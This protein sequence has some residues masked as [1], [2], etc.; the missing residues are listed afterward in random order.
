MNPQS[1]APTLIDTLN[2]ASSLELFQLSTIIE[3]MLADPRRIVAVR[4]NIKLGQLVRFLGCHDGQLRNGKVITMRSTQVVLREEGTLREWTL[5]YAAVDAP[6]HATPPLMTSTSTA[7]PKNLPTR[8]DFRCGERVSFNDKYLQPQVGIVMRINRRT[9]TID[10]GDG[11]SL[12]IP[13]HMLRPAFA[14][15]TFQSDPERPKRE[16]GK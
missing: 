6:K 14:F 16:M 3:R 7:P 13:F 2:H 1:T 15:C 11:H 5:P 4:S 8:D 9:A 12:R 10:T